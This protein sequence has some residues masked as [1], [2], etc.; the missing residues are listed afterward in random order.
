[1]NTLLI[2][3]NN[4]EESLSTLHR[5]FIPHVLLMPVQP[6]N[7]LPVC[8]GKNLS[9]EQQLY[10]CDHFACLPPETGLRNILSKIKVKEML[11]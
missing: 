4:I 2:A 8:V 3:G 9:G 11:E 7:Q 10:L 1:L 6:G 5:T